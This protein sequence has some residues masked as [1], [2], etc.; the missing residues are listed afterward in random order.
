MSPVSDVETE[1]PPAVGS[2]TTLTYDTIFVTRD[3]ADDGSESTSASVLREYRS[4][5]KIEDPS[6]V[7]SVTAPIPDIR[8]DQPLKETTDPT[9][10]EHTFNPT[11][12]TGSSGDESEFTLAL[13]AIRIQSA[14]VTIDL[15]DEESV[16]STVP[17]KDD[18]KPETVD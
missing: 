6:A 7:E 15:S 17:S 4:P 16:F 10:A 14:D 3:P 9:D 18:T 13:V 12:R 1:D 8:R 2:A 5:D 11:L